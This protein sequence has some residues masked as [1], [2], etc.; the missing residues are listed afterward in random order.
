MRILTSEIMCNKAIIDDKPECGLALYPARIRSV[1]GV[2]STVQ[3][4]LNTPLNHL[5][6]NLLTACNII[7]SLSVV[8]H[9]HVISG[10]CLG[11]ER[12]PRLRIRYANSIQVIIFSG[13]RLLERESYKK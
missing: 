4:N 2:F 8:V 3:L 6:L 13:R 5:D 7:L 12:P 9:T 1:S 10:P 11:G